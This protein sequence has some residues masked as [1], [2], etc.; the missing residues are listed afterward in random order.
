MKEQARCRAAGC[1]DIRVFTSGG[2]FSGHATHLD[3]RGARWLP[4]SSPADCDLDEPRLPLPSLLLEL[5]ICRPI[6]H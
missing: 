2:F 5:L 3:L 1:N 4:S 6:I